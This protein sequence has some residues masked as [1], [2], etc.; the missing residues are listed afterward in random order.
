MVDGPKCL[1]GCEK[2]SEFYNLCTVFDF[3]FKKKKLKN[4]KKTMQRIVVT[5][6]ALS[7]PQRHFG[8]SIIKYKN[9]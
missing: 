4:K 9:A 6:E 5:S 7:Q 8:A 1:W 3:N 2:A